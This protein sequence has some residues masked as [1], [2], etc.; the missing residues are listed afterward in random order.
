MND[1]I[2][3]INKYAMNGLKELSE[4]PIRT[5]RE[6]MTSLV[7]DY[8]DAG[9]AVAS[10]LAWTPYGKEIYSP[11]VQGYYL[12]WFG[13][14]TSILAGG[15]MHLNDSRGADRAARNGLVVAS[16]MGFGN[17]SLSSG[18]LDLLSVLNGIIGVG[19]ASAATFMEYMRRNAPIDK[20]L[21]NTEMLEA[22]ISKNI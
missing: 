16:T 6:A 8:W 22:Q 14:L 17:S 1:L 13:T 4:H 10:G 12:V 7:K 5:S 21:T 2:E 3:R 18:K 15:L 19:S 9:L 11:E 20:K